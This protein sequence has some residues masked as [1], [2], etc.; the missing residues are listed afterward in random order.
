MKEGFIMSIHP[1]VKD[2]LAQ[3]LPDDVYKADSL[4]EHKMPSRASFERVNRLLDSL[5]P[6]QIEKARN[7]AHQYLFGKTPKQ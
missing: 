1:I 6:E 4:L 7:A 2:F 3:P 5:T